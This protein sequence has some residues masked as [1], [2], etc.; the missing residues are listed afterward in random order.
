M[1]KVETS[2]LYSMIEKLITLTEQRQIQWS[3]AIH[4]NCGGQFDDYAM[5][6]STAYVMKTYFAEYKD[7]YFYVAHLLPKSEKTHD[8]NFLNN[9]YHGVY[10]EPSDIS[11]LK[12]YYTLCLQP[13]QLSPVDEIICENTEDINEKLY[14]LYNIIS[15]ALNESRSFIDDFLQEEV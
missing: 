6:H 1:S 15:D 13:S 14:L 7:G 10:E 2:T 5:Y 4:G 8:S 12:D 9:C 11:Q 3:V